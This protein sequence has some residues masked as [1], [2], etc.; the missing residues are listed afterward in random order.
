MEAV[1]IAVRLALAGHIV[2]GADPDASVAPTGQRAPFRRCYE[3][4]WYERVAATASAVPAREKS[5]CTAA[6]ERGRNPRVV[7]ASIESD[8]SAVGQE[9]DVATLIDEQPV[10]DAQQTHCSL[11]CNRIVS[12]YIGRPTAL[13]LCAGASDCQ[14]GEDGNQFH[15]CF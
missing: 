2:R 10:I 6:V 4:K 11:C 9:K 12:R 14:R 5:G 13:L 3:P 7:F 15:G 1:I 8:R